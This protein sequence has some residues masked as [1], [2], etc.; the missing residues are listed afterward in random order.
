MTRHFL[1]FLPLALSLPLFL[2]GCDGLEGPKADNAADSKEMLAA[3]EAERVGNYDEAIRLY[4]LTIDNYKGASLA[5]LQLA[6]L[7]HEHKKDYLGAIF[8]YRKYIETAEKKG[9]HDFTIVSNRI[10]KV[11]QLLSAKYVRAVAESEPDEGVQLMRSYAELD[12][13]A[14]KLRS[15]NERLTSSNETLRAE[16]VRLNNKIDQQL[17]WIKK[18]QTSPGSGAPTGGRIDSVTVTDADGNDK[19]LQTYEV[20]KGDNLSQIAAYVYGDSKL[21][22]RIRDA[23]PE[24][25]INERVRPGDILIIP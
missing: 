18:I 25:V 24:K 1:G 9:I 3:I 7:L 12:A 13:R 16:I 10:E 11:E 5:N 23:N 4:R 15:Q 22:P 14:S 6:I 8:H 19:I 21:W 20:R 17:L 2:A